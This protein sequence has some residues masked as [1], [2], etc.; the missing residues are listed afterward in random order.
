ML[1]GIGKYLTV[2][3][4]GMA[5]GAA[6]VVPGVSGGTI[7]FITGIYGEL[8]D[9][10]RSIDH[11]AV[12]CL[13]Q[14]GIKAAWSHINGNFL[15]AVFAGVLLSML[16]LAKLVTWCL[17]QQ[18]ILVWSGFF[19]LVLASALVL[20]RQVPHWTLWRGLW[21]LA[22]LAL[23]L[24]VSVLKPSQLEPSPLILFGAGAIAICAMILPGISGS[25]LLLMMGLYTA[26]IGALSQL[27]VLTLLPFAAG[28]ALGLL[29][30]SHLL[31]WLLH[32]FAAATMAFL[33]GIL[34]GSLN[35]IWPW[36][37]TLESVVNRHGELVPLVQQNLLPHQYAVITGEAS[38]W[39]L[40]LGCALSGFVIVVVIEAGA[41]KE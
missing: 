17:E 32:R 11:R 8:I 30:F 23:A 40:A 26:V 14:K 5:M 13:W 19:G 39:L 15:L 28:A 9:S 18:P 6:D 35:I 24:G 12:Q 4:R 27:Q 34:L 31:S 3:L 2:F 29:A 37:Q 36:K 38:Q 21:L 16:S 25:F 10:L 22:G 20:L 1:Q 7:A 33:T 41:G